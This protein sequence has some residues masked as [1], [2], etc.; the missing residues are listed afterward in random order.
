MN[1]RAASDGLPP[2]LAMVWATRSLIQRGK[3]L[4]FDQ[5]TEVPS[6]AHSSVK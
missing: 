2:A 6:L 3:R 1:P 5:G 4:V